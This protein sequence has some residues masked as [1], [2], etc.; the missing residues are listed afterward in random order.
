MVIFTPIILAMKD[1]ASN[2]LDGEVKQGNRPQ[3]HCHE[4]HLL[5]DAKP[6][7]RCSACSTPRSAHRVP[8]ILESTTNR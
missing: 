5:D 6:K 1:L 3:V 4:E 7:L 2:Y 8:Q